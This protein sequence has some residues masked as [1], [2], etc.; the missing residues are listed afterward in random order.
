MGIDRYQRLSCSV[1]PLS[2]VSLLINT[3][4]CMP[5][6]CASCELPT[7]ASCVRASCGERPECSQK[8]SVRPWA[9]SEPRADSQT[10]GSE[11]KFSHRP[12]STSSAPTSN[13]V[14][15]SV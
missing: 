3:S 8:Q 4:S 11:K 7:S 14:G 2:M 12:H 1:Q 6:Y 15:I 9:E 5:S 13:L 10:C